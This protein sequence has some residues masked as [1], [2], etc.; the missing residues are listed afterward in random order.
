MDRLGIK[1][2]RALLRAAAGAGRKRDKQRGHPR[3]AGRHVTPL[4]T[5]HF[6]SYHQIYHALATALQL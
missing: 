4:A 5:H 6:M 3:H 1:P 2:R